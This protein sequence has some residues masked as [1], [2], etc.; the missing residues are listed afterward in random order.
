[1]W[2]CFWKLTLGE[3]LHEMSNIKSMIITFAVRFGCFKICGRS[4]YDS[5]PHSYHLT[6]WNGRSWCIR[7]NESWRFVH[8]WIQANGPQ[9][10]EEW[11]LRISIGAT[12][13]YWVHHKNLVT[14]ENRAP[15]DDRYSPLVRF[16]FLLFKS[17][18]V[19]GELWQTLL[20]HEHANAFFTLFHGNSMETPTFLHRKAKRVFLNWDMFT[21]KS[22]DAKS[23]S[24]DRPNDILILGKQ[25]TNMNCLDYFGWLDS[26]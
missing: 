5:D 24:H 4:L 18:V 13:L 15:K 20:S 16:G 1:M 11:C 2:I 9:Y 17:C 19:S 6:M 8:K 14:W 7:L 25:P 3:I 22:T 10:R 12:S 26:H 21:S 23:V